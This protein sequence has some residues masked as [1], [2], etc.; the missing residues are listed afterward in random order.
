MSSF[1]CYKRSS[2]VGRPII[3]P[4]RGD[5]AGEPRLSPSPSNLRTFFSSV[6]YQEFLPSGSD[7]QRFLCSVRNKPTPQVLL[8]CKEQT[9]IPLPMFY[10][11]LHVLVIPLHIFS[12]RKIGSSTQAY[13]VTHFNIFI[14]GLFLHRSL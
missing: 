4:P 2:W 12:E 3:A 11:S 8:F 14:G 1:L 10:V 6:L 5:I 9:T 13:M 7:V